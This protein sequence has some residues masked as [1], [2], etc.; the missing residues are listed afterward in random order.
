M[1]SGLTDMID[2]YEW[3]DSWYANTTALVRGGGSCTAVTYDTAASNP[4]VFRCCK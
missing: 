1:N 2:D 3:L 4:N